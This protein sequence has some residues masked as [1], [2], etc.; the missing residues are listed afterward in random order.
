MHESL[1]SGAQGGE[2]KGADADSSAQVVAD[3]Q[4]KVSELEMRAAESKKNLEAQLSDMIS[5]LD[6]A[7]VKTEG[8]K[9]EKKKAVNDA[10]IAREE[11]KRLTEELVVVSQKLKQSQKASS[12][13]AEERD[14]LTSSFDAKIE[15][16]EAKMA[17]QRED[18]VCKVKKEYG[19]QLTQR[20]LEMAS[21][22]EELGREM[23]G[24]KARYDE[25]VE[26][27]DA[28][29]EQLSQRL[30][31]LQSA[32]QKNSASASEE[33]TALQGQ[34]DNLK[35]ELEKT[36]LEHSHASEKAKAD[37]EELRRQIERLQADLTEAQQRQAD[38]EAQK[39]DTTSPSEQASEREADWIAAV[40]ALNAERIR[41]GSLTEKLKEIETQKHDVEKNL[42]EVREKFAKLQALAKEKLA[43]A[44]EKAKA[45]AE[46]I[47][48]VQGELT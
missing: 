46:K 2:S 7:N 22:T 25:I 8:M 14:R 36:R 18:E 10:Q 11:C 40:E 27:K 26:E 28:E 44:E 47:A 19:E 3:L 1:G 32:D 16:L 12:E 20:N 21:M 29:L 30:K 9:A 23:V 4:A 24:L 5:V 13:I 33:E 37:I 17:E 38:A 42:E 45:D 35:L 31:D 48:S 41:S 34:V 15:L 43:K 6:Q 39:T